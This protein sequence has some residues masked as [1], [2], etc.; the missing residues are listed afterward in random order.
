MMQ[1]MLGV[2]V[3]SLR[4]PLQVVSSASEALHGGQEML[5]SPGRVVRM[6]RRSIARS[7]WTIANAAIIF[8]KI[9]RAR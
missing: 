7:T 1:G 8:R 4:A 3:S 6:T 5:N 9:R 2:H